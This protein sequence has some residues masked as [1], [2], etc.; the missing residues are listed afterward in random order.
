MLAEAAR[1]RFRREALTLARAY[2]TPDEQIIL[3]AILAE[4]GG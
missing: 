1:K 3:R 2:L 4:R